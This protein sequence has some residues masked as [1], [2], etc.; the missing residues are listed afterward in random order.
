MTVPAV[1]GGAAPSVDPAILTAIAQACRDTEGLEFTY[2]AAGGEH[3]TRH[4]EPHRLVLLGRRWYL[5]AYDLTRYDWRS[6]RL[7]RLAEPHATGGR[8][9]PR[10]VP[11]GDAAEFVRAGIEN[12]PASHRVEVLVHAPAAAIRKR[13]GRWG[14]I[15][16]LGEGQCLLQM[17]SDSLD[18]PVMALGTAGA[19]FEVL[20]PPELLDSVRE[21]GERFCRAVARTAPGAGVA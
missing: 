14:T 15:E 4:V 3:S 7:D 6:F 10:E 21:W 18:W 11:T 17:T 9:R 19:D 5:V 8:F 12:V 13:I 20:A 1:W 2:T 16:E